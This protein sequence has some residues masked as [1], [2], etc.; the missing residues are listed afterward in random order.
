MA[1]L[2]GIPLWVPQKPR[3]FLLSFNSYNLDISDE[4]RQGLLWQGCNASLLSYNLV[5]LYPSLSFLYYPAPGPSFFNHRY[6]IYLD[7]PLTI[8]S[9]GTTPATDKE[10]QAQHGENHYVRSSNP[11]LHRRRLSKPQDETVTN[12]SLEAKMH[13]KDMIQH[14]LRGDTWRW[15]EIRAGRIKGKKK[16]NTDKRNKNTVIGNLCNIET[17]NINIL[18]FGNS[19]ITEGIHHKQNINKKRNQR[20]ETLNYPLTNTRNEIVIKQLVVI[21]TRQI[22]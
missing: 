7:A 21:L 13:R 1:K 16:L 2:K 4:H 18:Q 20:I 14:K 8:L 6:T 17:T 19:W 3:T 11:P 9:S 15:C 22:N 5:I 10:G 12:R